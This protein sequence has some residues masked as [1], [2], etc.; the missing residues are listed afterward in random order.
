MRTVRSSFAW[1]TGWHCF[2]VQSL[3][4][5]AAP[6]SCGEL[7]YE[8][9]VG[10]LLATESCWSEQNHLIIWH[11]RVPDA[12]KPHGDISSAVLGAVLG[13][14]GAAVLQAAA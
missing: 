2:L 6:V 14:T 10:N 1:L 7:M 3:Y 11:T 13:A 5:Y 4:D 9:F 8:C 12:S